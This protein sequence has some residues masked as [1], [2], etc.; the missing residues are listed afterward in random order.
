[1][2]FTVA[3]VGRP[4]VGKSTLFNR[5]LGRRR[6]IVNDQPG[7]TRDLNEGDA[8][9][10]GVRFRV[11]DTAGWSENSVASLE[12][13]AAQM[14]ERAIGLADVA[15]FVIDGRSAMMPLDETFARLLHRLGRPVVIAANKCE[16]SAVLPGLDKAVALGFGEALPISAQHNEGIDDLVV[17]LAAAAGHAGA[18]AG[19]PDEPV[20]ER[21]VSLA[22]VGRP[23]VGKSTLVNCLL[24][25]ERMLTGPEPGVTRDAI[26]AKWQTDDGVV[27]LVDTAGLR[28]QARIVSE[29]EQHAAGAAIS[30]IRHADIVALI[31]DATA[32]MERQDLHICR[33]A[34]EEGKPLIVVANK[35]DMVESRSAVARLIRERVEESLAQVKGV[36]VVYV[37][38][39]TGAGIDKIP[40]AAWK[41]YRAWNTKISTAALNR[42][43]APTLEKHAPPAV[44]G[45]RIRIRYLTQT[46]A[47][48][49]TFVLF[50]SQA[51]ALPDS[52]LAYLANGLRATFAMP[53][54]P[55]RLQLRQ[56]KNPYAQRKKEPEKRRRRVTRRR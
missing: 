38:A 28:K 41:S 10:H 24:G 40:A 11:I 14:T 54:T 16:P 27:E 25:E 32:P 2:S 15:L 23:N 12:G 30:A 7:V 35:W 4:N 17:A 43:L 55:I 19:E 37:S 33:V 26:A 13:R 6:A 18:G 47:R 36:P 56:G 52:Y 49:P 42:W 21:R 44:R 50:A 48:P 31:L 20:V 51:E 29:L 46:G 53:G 1:M 9:A 5:L 8:D 39:L 22:I 45:R 3:I 34:T